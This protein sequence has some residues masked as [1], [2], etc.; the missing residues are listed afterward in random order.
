MT[1]AIAN[2]QPN[3]SHPPQSQ[4][5]RNPIS[6]FLI[7]LDTAACSASQRSSGLFLVV[8]ERVLSGGVCARPLVESQH[9]LDLMRLQIAEYTSERARAS[10]RLTRLRSGHR[11]LSERR[12]LAWSVPR[13]PCTYEP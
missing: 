8:S 1:A 11:S 7:R 9:E 4:P 2:R 3:R 12:I 13:S 10:E 5:E 6:G